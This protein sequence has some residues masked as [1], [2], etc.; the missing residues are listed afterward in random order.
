MQWK[1]S[2]VQK[3]TD[4]RSKSNLRVNGSDTDFNLTQI[5]FWHETNVNL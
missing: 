1:D 4:N 5:K 3:E 2:N